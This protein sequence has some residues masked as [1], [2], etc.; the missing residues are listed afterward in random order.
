MFKRIQRVNKTLDKRARRGQLVEDEGPRELALDEDTD[1]DSD[2]EASSA[3]TSDSDPGSEDDGS[4]DEGRD[5]DHASDHEV[6]SE[7]EA[8]NSDGRLSGRGS[9]RQRDGQSIDPVLRPSID[10]ALAD[11]IYIKPDAIE[12]NGS[13]HRSCYICPVALLKTQKMA[14]VHISSGSHL[15]RL[16]RVQASIAKLSELDRRE[17]SEGGLDIVTVVERVNEA[18]LQRQEKELEQKKVKEAARKK[19]KADRMEKKAT[20]K[21]KSNEDGT[22]VVSDK[23]ERRKN[24]RARKALTATTS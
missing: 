15:R 13:K 17:P 16:K 20:K 8:G 10:K 7:E 2:S 1:S 3:S 5:A 6:D 14:D 24:K 4:A 18:V 22:T 23:K 21:T 19:R 11:S 9:H 12:S